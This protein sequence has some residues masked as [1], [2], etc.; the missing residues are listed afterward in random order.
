ML[1]KLHRSDSNTVK[2]TKDKSPQWLVDSLTSHSAREQ[3]S[4]P[5]LGLEP[6]AIEPTLQPGG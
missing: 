2:T 1:T 3:R 6:A 5:F 4:S